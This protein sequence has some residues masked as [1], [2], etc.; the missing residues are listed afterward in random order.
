MNIIYLKE[1]SD[2]LERGSLLRTTS[3]LISSMN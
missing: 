3:T 1:R 2:G